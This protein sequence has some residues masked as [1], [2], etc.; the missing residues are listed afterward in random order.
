MAVCVS[1]KRV[2]NIEHDSIAAV[3]RGETIGAYRKIYE[4]T[5]PMPRPGQ[6]SA[7]LISV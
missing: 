3:W 7:L 2:G 1:G 5:R 4:R 6:P